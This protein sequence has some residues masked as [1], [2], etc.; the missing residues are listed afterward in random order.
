MTIVQG[1]DFPTGGIIYDFNEIKEGYRTGRGRVLIAPKP[2]LKKA[3][4]WLPDF[5]R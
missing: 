1:P 2:E 4:R 5:G 3:K